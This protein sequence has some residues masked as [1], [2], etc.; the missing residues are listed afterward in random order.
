[1]TD[2][3][4][5]KEVELSISPDLQ[6]TDRDAISVRS[7]PMIILDHIISIALKDEGRE[8]TTNGD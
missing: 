4:W 2:T 1:M 6:N 3:W 7:G 5:I 8:P